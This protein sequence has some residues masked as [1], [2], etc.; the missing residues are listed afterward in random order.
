[1]SA[2][3]SGHRIEDHAADGDPTPSERASA[4]GVGLRPRGALG[5]GS[6]RGANEAKP[7]S[8]NDYAKGEFRLKVYPAGVSFERLGYVP[9]EAP[10]VAERGVIAGFSDKA[11]RR[12]KEFCVTQHAPNLVPW[13]ITLTVHKSVSPGEWRAIL[14]RFRHRVKD[15]GWAGVWR[16][17]LQR[18]KVPHLH[19]VL[20]LWP[21]ESVGHVASQWLQSTGEIYDLAAVKHAV[22]GREIESHGWVVYMALH[23]GKKKEAQLGWQGKQ[24]GV[25]NRERFEPRDPSPLS[26]DLSPALNVAV[27][28]FLLRWLTAQRRAKSA[29][30]A[31]NAV[32]AAHAGNAAEAA[33]AAEKARALRRPLRLH[34]GNLLRCLEGA[35]VE[36]LLRAIDAGRVAHVSRAV[37][38]KHATP[39]A[40]IP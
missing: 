37:H 4:A 2:C 39:L 20:W 6:I 32:K 18:R 31:G 9:Q 1:M 21:G 40:P 15:Q 35:H 28:R 24:W 22:R 25:W 30:H 13:S 8:R 23:D 34:R 26:R 27:R 16:V 7:H 17:E 10:E 19:V 36:N 11:A 29:F 33:E 12:L 5:I 14:G 38:A 3:P